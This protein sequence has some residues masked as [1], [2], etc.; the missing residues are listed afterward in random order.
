MTLNRVMHNEEKRFDEAPR[1]NAVHIAS[2]PM[3]QSSA[4]CAKRG[5]CASRIG[6][7]WGTVFR[8]APPRITHKVLSFFFF[9]LVNSK[10]ARNA[11]IQAN[12]VVAEMRRRFKT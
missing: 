2:R 1:D 11:P 5:R 7:R 8:R 6:A 12:I 3:T 4:H 9:L 10:K